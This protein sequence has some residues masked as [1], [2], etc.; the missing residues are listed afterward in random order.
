M[1]R[2]YNDALV[3]FWEELF[4]KTNDVKL[5]Y[6]IAGI[7]K[8]R[9]NTIAYKKEAVYYIR[10]H[11]VS[12]IISLNNIKTESPCVAEFLNVPQYYHYYCDHLLFSIGQIGSRFI[13]TSRM[14]YFQR[15]LVHANRK[16]FNFREG[17][18]KNLS[19]KEARNII[20]HIDERDMVVIE[21]N[22]G[23]GGF[24]VILSSGEKEIEDLRRRRDTHIYTLDLVEKKLLLFNTKN[25]KEID[26]ELDDV[27]I[28]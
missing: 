6:E 14:S 1:L 8:D 9:G 7:K 2:E 15:S 27:S 28:G 12:A 18:Y 3:N 11:I 5:S 17:K 21:D 19:N 22:S 10:H 24:N 25:K 26:I 4:K 20:E 13:E 16:L 23:V